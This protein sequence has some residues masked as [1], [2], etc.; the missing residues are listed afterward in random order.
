MKSEKIDIIELT[1]IVSKLGLDGNPR[2][3]SL[4]SSLA[5]NPSKERLEQLM[6]ILGP[7]LNDTALNPDPFMP[8]P[9]NNEVDGEIKLGL[10][11]TMAIFGLNVYELM[12]GTLIA[13]RPG[14]GKTTTTYNIIHRANKLGIHCL[15]LDIK[16]DYRHLI[17]KIPN[18]LVF[19]ADSENFKWNPLEAPEGID[20][21]SHITNFADIT[22]EAHAIY[23]GTNNYLI[24]HLNWLYDKN[25]Q[26][27]LFD[28]Y[29]LIR[30]KKEALI[31]RT[32]RYRESALNRLASIMVKMGNV[33]KHRKGYRIEKLLNDY[34]VVIELDNLGNKGTIYLSSLILSS[35]FQHRI[36]NNLRGIKQKPVLVIIDEGNEIFDK[37]L[38]R[39]LGGLTLTSMAREAREFQLGLV[40]SCQIPDAISDSIKNVYTRILLSLSE[41]YNL[42]HFGESMGLTKEQ[43]GSNFSLAPGQAIIRLAGRYDK[44][45]LVQFIPYPIDK[46]VSNEEIMNHMKPLL[47]K[48]NAEYGFNQEEEKT[49]IVG[50]ESK[51]AEENPEKE[52]SED[53]K[54]FLMNIYIH[55]YSSITQHYENL[56]LSAGKGNGIMKK[57]IRKQL[58]KIEQINLGGRGGLT[59]FLVMTEAGQEILGVKGKK[60]TGRGAGFEHGFWQNKISA[61]FKE[62]GYK[63]EIEKNLN[64]KF[65]DVGIETEKGIIAIEI[66]ISS[67][68]EK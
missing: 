50:Q 1:Q 35:V 7:Y 15:I 37:N 47:E 57:L 41:G 13:G 39:Q 19:R 32:A 48:I 6:R 33:F 24:E 18:T 62:Q 45:F 53:E 29:Y 36:A 52:I 4:L 10:C 40:C 21:I 22:S 42:R 27:T 59:K 54:L 68:H 51:E 8:C 11:P 12:Q 30:S 28:L 26:P 58:C 63:T 20:N 55:P 65:L 56:D 5:H 46:N 25:P 23:D 9:R 17:R 61:H 44:P 43:M 64:S 14:A 49:V 3:M 34:N 31:T 67:E 38:E 2:V 16:K 60:Q 66:A